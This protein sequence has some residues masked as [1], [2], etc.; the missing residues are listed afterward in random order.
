MLD[1]FLV[2]HA[3]AMIRI[4][5]KALSYLVNLFVI[6]A[7]YYFFLFDDCLVICLSPTLKCYFWVHRISERRLCLRDF[8]LGFSKS[9]ISCLS[10]L[11]HGELYLHV[12]TEFLNNVEKKKERTSEQ[13]FVNV[14]I[15]I[16]MPEMNSMIHSKAS[17]ECLR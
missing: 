2:R 13:S 5:A 4:F 7:S 1:C 8:F 15:N 16:R 3:Y 14:V 12:Y 11:N 10:F 17:F 6:T 9:G